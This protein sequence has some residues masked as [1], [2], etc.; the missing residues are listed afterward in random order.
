[1]RS[2][3]EEAG[4]FYIIKRPEPE[5]RVISVDFKNIISSISAVISVTAEPS[6]LVEFDMNP[7]EISDIEF[8]ETNLI[9]KITAGT[10]DE[11]YEVTCVVE[12]NIGNVI[13]E[14]I[15]IKVRKSGLI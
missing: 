13:S 5:E 11:N 10:L 14:D 9:F 3:D 4:L 8:I 1:M 6:G 2:F 15:L 12:D 7:L